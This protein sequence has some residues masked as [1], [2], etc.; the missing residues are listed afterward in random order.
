MEEEEEDSKETIIPPRFPSL[1]VWEVSVDRPPPRIKSSKKEERGPATA[2][3]ITKIV[4][5]AVATA[6]VFG[7]SRNPCAQGKQVPS[8]SVRR[9]GS[10]RLR[11]AARWNSS[12]T[13]EASTARRL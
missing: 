11:R 1:I 13:E 12:E 4:K 9:L 7:R 2:T 3:F 6:A 8:S 5:D 10:S